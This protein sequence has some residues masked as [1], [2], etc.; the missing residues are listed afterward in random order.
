[1]PR[2]TSHQPSQIDHIHER[3]EQA[4]RRL[5]GAPGSPR[6]S[7]P[8][9]EPAVDVYETDREIV[10]VAEI[11][12]IGRGEIQ[13]E[14]DGTNCTL[15]GERKPSRGGPKRD[16]RQM[17]ISHGPFFREVLLPAEVNRDAV[18]TVYKD[19]MLQITLPKASPRTH[20][21]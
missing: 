14:I 16:Y 6:F 5:I 21:G 3:M 17:E 1:M 7:A 15:R 19:G 11:A 20:N 10:I 12:G 9:M 8:F 18:A 13:L 2:R 4:R